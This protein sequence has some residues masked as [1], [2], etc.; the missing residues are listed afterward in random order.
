M[1]II[2]TRCS[3][4]DLSQPATSKVKIPS[5]S[6]ETVKRRLFELARKDVLKSKKIR[7][8]QKCNYKLKLHVRSLKSLLKHLKEKNHLNE[9][10][11]EV[12]REKFGGNFEIIKILFQKSTG[13]R[14]SR[15]YN[16]EIRSFAITLHFYSPKGYNYVREKFY[17]CLPHPK[18]LSKWYTSVDAKS[19]FTAESFKMLKLKAENS[20]RPIVGSVVFDEMSIRKLVEFNHYSGTYSGYVDFG[21]NLQTDSDNIAKDAL[22]FMFVALN[23]AWKVPIGYFFTHSLN[24]EQKSTLLLLCLAKLQECGVIVTNMTFDGIYCNFTM[25]K[26]LGCKFEK[27]L[28]T[29]VAKPNIYAYPDPPHMIKLIRTTFAEKGI[30]IDGMGRQINFIYLKKLNELQ[31]SD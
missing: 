21:N 31:E 17:N 4:M 28:E 6:K 2:Q 3:E 13:K 19:G 20:D 27:D 25:C 10:T 18:T 8:L 23:Q 16:Q 7:K 22:V 15:A 1:E 30:L 5:P 29:K 24:S 11:T 9:D 14:V 12:L 26:L